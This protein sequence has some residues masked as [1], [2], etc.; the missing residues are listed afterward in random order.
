MTMTED[1]GAGLSYGRSTEPGPSWFVYFGGDKIGEFQKCE[2]GLCYV[3]T[4]KLVLNIGR[5]EAI[6]ALLRRLEEQ[7]ANTK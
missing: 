6:A 1:I 5:L 3:P 4:S 2:I 7:H